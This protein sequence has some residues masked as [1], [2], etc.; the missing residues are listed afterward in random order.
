[1][2]IAGGDGK[3]PEDRLLLPEQLFDQFDPGDIVADHMDA[4]V[5]VLPSLRPGEPGAG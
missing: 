4:L 1:M 2:A 3:R 5:E